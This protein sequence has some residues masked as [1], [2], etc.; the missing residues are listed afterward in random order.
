MH[1]NEGARGAWA[2]AR[3]RLIVSCQAAAPDAFDGA[4]LMA[5]F[6][7]AAVDGGAGGIRAHGAADVES[8][9]S[10]VPVPILGIHKEVVE[11]GQILITPT[12]DRAVELA[13]AGADAIGVD[14]S[15]RGIVRGAHDRLQR[16]RRELGLPAMADIATRE[17]AEA[18]VRHGASFVLSTMRGYT[19][20]TRHLRGRFEPEFIA[21]LVRRCPVPVIAEGGI[22]SPE[23]AASAVRAGAWAVVVGSAITRPHLITREFADALQDG[24]GPQW[25][26]AIDVGGTNIKYG[27]VARGGDIYG[28]GLVPTPVGSAEQVLEQ[29]RIALRT[30]LAQAHG[31]EVECVSIA[32]AGWLD[33]QAGSV[34][35][36]TGNL[37]GWA[38]A[39]LRAAV[40]NETS[41]P[42]FFENDGV[43]AAAGEWLYG[44]ARGVRSGVCVTLGTGV[45]GGA[46]VEG[47]LLRGGHGLA[48][49]LGH[50]P[51]PGAWMP[52]TCGLTGCAETELGKVGATRLVASFGSLEAWTEAVL[53][54]DPDACRLL[55]EYAST[56]AGSLL[57]AVHLL[58]PEVLVFTG[59]LASAGPLLVG[60]LR[61]SLSERILAWGQRRIRIEV[62]DAGGY[63]G[64]RGA[65]AIAALEWGRR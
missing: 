53:G 31:P 48:G 50:L 16:I 42:A 62:S 30:C 49:M 9:R 38:G 4:G 44:A 40:A 51:L 54:K 5:R 11:D 14:C 21:E 8:I 7:R 36:A 65:G 27:L 41:L 59:G 52:C 56:L 64:V 24:R 22:G 18:A 58:D 33:R 32:A 15:Q 39:D 19:A 43:A 61:R 10:A 60:A 37:P 1:M 47:R 25:T 6:A 12:F 26:A 55:E 17:E 20:E 2:E 57:P 3:G 29:M 46:I 23:E 34:S 28:T 63:A 13:R 35:Y 45:G